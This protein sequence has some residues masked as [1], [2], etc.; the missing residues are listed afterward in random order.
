[1]VYK[2]EYEE[3]EIIQHVS[4]Q[5]YSKQQQWGMNGA[6]PTNLLSLVQYTSMGRKNPE[7]LWLI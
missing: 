5:Q 1:M 6:Y 7:V 3:N 2:T 4:Y